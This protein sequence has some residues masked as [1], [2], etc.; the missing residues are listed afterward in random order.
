MVTTKNSIP[1]RRRRPG[2]F[3]CQ[4]GV[5]LIM[6]LICLFVISTLAVGI[7]YSTQS[8]IWTTG[9]YRAVEQA[10]YVAEAGAQ[11]A[12]TYLQTQSPI[13]SNALFTSSNFAINSMP[14]LYG[15]G[16]STVPTPSTCATPLVLST[17]GIS[18]KYCD[19]F[20]PTSNC[21][22]ITGIDHAVGT[23]PTIDSGFQ[24][25]F[26]ASSS[27]NLT[28][29]PFA[30]LAPG[31]SG[32]AC[33]HFD[34]A[35]QL[36]QVYAQSST[37]WLTR[38]KI[39]SEGRL[40]TVGSNVTS[41]TGQA[42][43]QVVEVVD[44][45]MTYTSSS[46]P[47]P[48]FVAGLF[49]TGTGCSPPPISMSGGQY[50]NGYT[51]TG[52]IG[53]TSPTLLNTNGNVGAM[54]NISI[55]GGAYILGNVYS[56]FYNAGTTGTYGISGGPYPGLNGSAACSTGT[57][58][59]VWA[60]NEDNS[61]SGVGCTA[62]N[63]SSC[64]QKTY[65]LPSPPPSYPTPTMPSVATNTAEPTGS[66]SGIW[67]GLLGGGS[68]GGNGCAVTVAPSGGTVTGTGG[69]TSPANFGAVNMGSC[70]VITL[71]AGTYNMD[72]LY[73]SNGAKI[74]LPSTGSVVINI[75][76]KG[77]ITNPLNID[78]G[79]MSNGGGAPA[80]LTIVYAGT[81]TINVDAGANMFGTVYA[82]NAAVTVSGNA[83]LYG[84]MV[85]KTAA[86]SGSG[87]VVYDTALNG[88]AVCASCVSG[89]SPTP[90]PGPLHIDEFSWSAF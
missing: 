13:I 72:S 57:G 14:V 4:S 70:A 59:T 58:G 64:S 65:T 81:K 46:N 63:N 6:A 1:T 68:G 44:N 39:V 77:T 17:S 48:T 87:H 55:G 32:S 21:S 56:P 82:P 25:Y 15:T 30:S 76:D 31:C 61:G 50:T 43:V 8:E 41:G 73:V 23:N 29:V 12:L 42:M 10:R 36:L 18:A 52:Q 62:M 90:I 47:I 35:V 60:V 85:V 79:T 53:S 45:V 16:C 27:S 40:S 88:K 2:K 69:F 74:I 34:V 5:A 71:Q 26:Y 7:L 38:W 49:A 51:S 28:Y 3:A 11:Q 22:T 66:S 54:G 78:G 24:S 67:Y 33:P 20:V 9:N 75:L 80:N 84:A 86:F 83:G 37:T 19:S 89:S